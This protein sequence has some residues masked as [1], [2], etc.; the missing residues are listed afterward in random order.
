MTVS[1]YDGSV[2]KD[3]QVIKPLKNEVGGETVTIEAS[4]LVGIKSVK[5]TYNKVSTGNLTLDDILVGYGGTLVIDPVAAYVNKSVDNVIS[6]DVSELEPETEYYYT[7]SA[8]NGTL[9]SK[10]SNEIKVITAK[11]ESTGLNTVNSNYKV[12][13]TNSEIIINTTSGNDDLVQIYNYAGQLIISR[14]IRQQVRISKSELTTGIY[15][16]KAGNITQKIII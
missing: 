10:K 2:W 11:D 6:F 4:N 9:F 8:T 1:G 7:I 16:L 13:I 14:T 3:I 5:F 12:V 15:I